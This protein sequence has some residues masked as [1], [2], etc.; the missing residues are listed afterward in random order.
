M[1]S[2]IVETVREFP[3]CQLQAVWTNKKESKQSLLIHKMTLKGTKKP[4]NF[5]IVLDSESTPSVDIRGEF[6]K[7]LL[8]LS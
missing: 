7:Y 5:S 1:D 3:C 4:T 6:A 8:Q 2:G